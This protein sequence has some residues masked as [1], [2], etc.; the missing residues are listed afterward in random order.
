[1]GAWYGSRLSERLST[2]MVSAE[3]YTDGLC[4]RIDLDQVRAV[5]ACGLIYTA[6]TSSSKRFRSM[7][8]TL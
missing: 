2:R 7:M 6:A 8:R 4:Y 1:V 3:S 5:A